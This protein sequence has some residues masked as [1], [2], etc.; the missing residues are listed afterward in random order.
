MRITFYNFA[1]KM[2]STAQPTIEDVAMVIDGYLKETTTLDR[3]TFIINSNSLPDYSYA[4]AF[5]RYYFILDI[6]SVANN[7]WEVTC[8]LDVLATNRNNI[9]NSTFYVERAS[10]AYTAQLYD[11]FYP[12]LCGRKQMVNVGA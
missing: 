11:T 12:S 9:G 1:K 3:P 10:S 2:N 7:L 5:E 8:K 4:Q 6:V